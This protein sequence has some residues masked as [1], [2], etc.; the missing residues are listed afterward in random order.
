MSRPYDYPFEEDEDNP[1]VY[2]HQR[3]PSD[4]EVEAALAFDGALEQPD[5]GTLAAEA[6]AMEELPGPPP[7]YRHIRHDTS[8]VQADL[9]ITEMDA[10]RDD[11]LGSSGSVIAESLHESLEAADDWIFEKALERMA[12]AVHPGAGRLINVLLTIKEIAGDVEALASP[13]SPRNLHVPLFHAAGLAVDL[14]VHLQGSDGVEDDAP[15]V[16]G[17]LSPGDDGLFGGW[18]IEVDRP[19]ESDE[20][21]RSESGR[22]AR[23]TEAEQ[24]TRPSAERA[25]RP[26]SQEPAA[27]PLIDDDMSPVKRLVKDPWRRAVVLREAAL[28]LRARLFARPEFAAETVL[29]VYDPLAG[30][31]MWLVK[32][33]L[34]DALTARRIEMWLNP[35]TG[36]TIVSIE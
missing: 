2:G 8:F 13:D 5:G 19:S 31:G 6:A 17:F 34:S 24:V 33:D 30:L 14:N 15:P 27:A 21:K 1:Q 4:A 16:S 11:I 12:N 25:K 29:I 22:D 28:R 32:P 20:K 35:A 26:R 23:P 3:G 7:G 9:P 18:E 10:R 36:V